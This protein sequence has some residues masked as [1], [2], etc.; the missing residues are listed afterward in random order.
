M[1]DLR[2]KSCNDSRMQVENTYKNYNCHVNSNGEAPPY[3]P[4]SDPS[5]MQD[6]R[7]YSASCASS[8]AQNNGQMN[9]VVAGGSGDQWEFKKGKSANG[10]A[11]KS[12]S[13]S[14]PE[15]KRKKRVA[16]YKVY[17]VEGK[18]K[19]SIKKSFGWLKERYTKMMYGSS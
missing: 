3:R 7:S 14:D 4:S 10:V 15:L 19:G 13:F 8:S 1:E 16:S 6:L 18:V 2:S 12:W 9:I 5:G 11:S 17:T